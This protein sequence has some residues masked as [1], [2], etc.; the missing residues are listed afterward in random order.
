MLAVASL[1]PPPFPFTLFV[2]GTF[3]IC[4]ACDG[5]ISYKRLQ[6]VP[7]TRYCINCQDLL[8]RDELNPTAETSRLPALD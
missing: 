5:T 8:E 1:M 4:I 3:G 7:W 2:A 6:A